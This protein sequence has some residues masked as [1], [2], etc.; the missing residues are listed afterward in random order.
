[1]SRLSSGLR[2]SRRASER[3]SAAIAM[4]SSSQRRAVRRAQLQGRMLERGPHRP[5]D[6]AR[7]LHH[8][9]LHQ[10]LD[11]GV[12]LLLV[13]EQLRHAGA[14]QLVVGREPIAL[15]P[16]RP[17]TP[18]RRRGRER[19]EQRQIGQHAR[20]HVDAVVGV[21]QLDMHVQPA[22][23]VA[24]ADHLQV[25]HHRVVALA[26]GLLRAAPVGGRMRAG[27]EDGE[28]VV[29]RDL[30]HG[31]AQMAQLG[32]GGPDVVMRQRRHLDLRLQEFAHDLAV[33]GLLGD[34]QK[35]LGHVARHQLGV[36]VDQEIFFLDAE[37]CRR[38]SWSRR[39]A[40]DVFPSAR[41]NAA[42]E[43]GSSGERS[44]STLRG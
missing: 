4:V 41:A 37:C 19:D 15:E 42:L 20:H 18:E 32:V 3:H 36:R 44:M 13:A 14:R 29:G 24:L 33:G 25:V 2:T 12:E 1:M 43:F 7:I 9:G 11:I 34:V 31:L 39:V 16:G 28:A 21:R 17:R 26:L 5:P 30:R 6:V 40:S 10:R 23:H 35:G 22:Q 27:G 8:A 38:P